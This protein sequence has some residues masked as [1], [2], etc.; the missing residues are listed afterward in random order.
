MFI[1]EYDTPMSSSLGESYSRIIS[2][3]TDSILSKAFKIRS[4]FIEKVLMTGILELSEKSLFSGL[5]DF[6]MFGVLQEE[7]SEFFGFTEDEVNHLLSSY[8]I[9]DIQLKE[10]IKDWYNGYRF[11][12]W[13]I[14]NPWSITN[15]LEAYDP[16]YLEK[17]IIQPYWIKSGKIDLIIK[18]FKRICSHSQIQLLFDEDQFEVDARFTDSFDYLHQL[19]CNISTHSIFEQNQDPTIENSDMYVNT[20]YSLLLQTG[21]LT[22]TEKEH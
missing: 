15:C 21:Y 22:I 13:I 10:K 17:N 9:S 19:L 6:K 8:K 11:S 16:Q 5:N 20:F 14:Y 1:D 4:D 12:R 18:I 3:I 7:Y 2:V